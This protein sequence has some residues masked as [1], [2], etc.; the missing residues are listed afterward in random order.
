MELSSSSVINSTN[1]LLSAEQCS[2]NTTVVPFL[3]ERENY[4]ASWVAIATYI[5]L[6][7]H[8]LSMIGN[9]ILISAFVKDIQ[10]RTTTNM[11]VVSHLSAEMAAASFGIV[12][13]T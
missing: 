4:G 8:I 2:I 9:G 11:L 5:F 7:F 1:A 3:R 6:S 10:M 12:T 13:H